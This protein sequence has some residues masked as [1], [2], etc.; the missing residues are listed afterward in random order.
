[1]FMK[2]SILRTVLS[3]V[4]VLSFVATPMIASASYDYTSYG[5]ANLDYDVDIT[6]VALIRAYIV[7]IKTFD[8]GD[9]FFTTADANVDGDVDIIDVVKI[10]S[11]IVSGEFGDSVTIRTD[12]YNLYI[13]DELVVSGDKIVGTLPKGVTY[14]NK[15]LTL[16]NATINVGDGDAIYCDDDL[17]IVCVGSNFIKGSA[18]AYNALTT[19][20]NL[21]IEGE[22]SLTIDSFENAI[23]SDL[24]VNINCDVNIY[25]VYSAVAAFEDICVD[26]S[27]ID[28]ASN[29]SGVSALGNITF[30]DSQVCINSP[31]GI[32]TFGS[33]EFN[34]CPALVIASRSDD[35]DPSGIGIVTFSE[36]VF[37]NTFGSITADDIAVGAV[38]F[39]AETPA[40]ITFD[41]V[42]IDSGFKYDTITEEADGMTAS[43]A[44]VTEGELQYDENN[45]IGIANA[46]TYL[47][48][49]KP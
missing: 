7:G 38:S 25:D 39:D 5:D 17:T 28:I 48:L 40:K 44:V 14:E 43:I 20:G 46:V 41:G 18:D 37:K 35:S 47:E 49:M 42:K 9:A 22:G 27:R 11:W 15:T 29:S 26:N 13:V 32:V 19:A 45:E 33:C 30:T 12:D 36:V 16:N 6:D 34:N 31:S 24:N 21:T 4:L 23:S 1:M 2:R 3:L 8:E 10:R